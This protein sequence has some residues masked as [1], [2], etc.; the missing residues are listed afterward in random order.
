MKKI[1][2]VFYF[3]EKKIV[4]FFKKNRYCNDWHCN[5]YYSIADNNDIYRYKHNAQNKVLCDDHI[6]K[7]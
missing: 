5:N 4:P 1:F 6:M 2:V 7:C 3:R